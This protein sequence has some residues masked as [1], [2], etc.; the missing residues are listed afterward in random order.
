MKQ[1]TAK[2]R[3]THYTENRG[4]LELRRAV[5]AFEQQDVLLADRIAQAFNK[6]CTV[7][8]A[9]ISILL[10]L[11]ATMCVVCMEYCNLLL[12][13]YAA[14]ENKCKYKHCLSHSA[15]LF[16]CYTSVAFGIYLFA[17]CSKFLYIFNHKVAEQMT[18][19]I[20]IIAFGKNG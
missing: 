15:S 17:S 2:T 11:N 3:C 1:N 6:Q 8:C 10:R 9:G 19:H 13:G 12:R 16:D 20:D 4:S 5:A 7:N 18:C 14:A